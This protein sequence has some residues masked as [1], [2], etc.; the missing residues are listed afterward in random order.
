MSYCGRLRSMDALESITPTERQR[1][2]RTHNE[3]SFVEEEARYNRKRDNT[4][5]TFFFLFVSTQHT[6]FNEFELLVLY[7]YCVRLLRCMQTNKRTNEN[8]GE[9]SDA[10]GRSLALASSMTEDNPLEN[11]KEMGV[12]IEYTY[13]R[14]LPGTA[15]AK[16]FLYLRNERR[17]PSF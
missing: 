10:G 1:Q 4:A 16:F 2:D 14:S 6:P 9:I 13:F 11:G 3:I 17:E 7:G 5:H 8:G 12:G 15:L